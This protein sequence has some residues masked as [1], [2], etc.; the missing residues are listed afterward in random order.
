MVSQFRPETR[1]GPEPVRRGRTRI[2]KNRVGSPPTPRS[3]KSSCA[4]HATSVAGPRLHDGSCAAPATGCRPHA[5]CSQ[6]LSPHLFIFSDPLDPFHRIVYSLGTPY[7]T[8]VYTY[9]TWLR[10]TTLQPSTRSRRSTSAIRANTIGPCNHRAAPMWAVHPFSFLCCSLGVPPSRSHQ[11]HAHTMPSP[12]RNHSVR[13]NTLLWFRRGP[14]RLSLTSVR[15][16]WLRASHIGRNSQHM[17][18]YW[19]T[20]A[21][22]V[23]ANLVNSHRC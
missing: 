18:I 13:S 22:P 11:S 16:T 21:R 6:P 12:M 10:S 17:P 1:P 15:L 4:G 19:S 3:S 23:V 8:F 2:L 7:S 20:L 5:M 14:A 9:P